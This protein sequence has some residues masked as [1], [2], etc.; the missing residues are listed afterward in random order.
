MLD[1]Q[2]VSIHSCKNNNL[3]AHP[4]VI[5]FRAMRS[6]RQGIERVYKLS[7]LVSQKAFIKIDLRQVNRDTH[8]RRA[9]KSIVGTTSTITS[10][11]L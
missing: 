11:A 8:T 9:T 1:E 2:A 7:N 5:H 10:P 4:S 6:V 3:R